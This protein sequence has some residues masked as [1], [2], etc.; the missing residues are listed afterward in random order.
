MIILYFFAG[1]IF[2]CLL[3]ACW[4]DGYFSVSS[5]FLE[6]KLSV[7]LRRRFRRQNQKG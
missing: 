4:M 2:I 7:F 6:G 5:L 3:I 1:A